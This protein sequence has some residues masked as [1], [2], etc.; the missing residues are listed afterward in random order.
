MGLKVFGVLEILCGA[1]AALMIP[2]MLLAQFLASRFN[3]D[4]A[5]LRQMVQGAVSYAV[6]AAAFVLVGIGS[7]QARRW[8]R[9]LSLILSWS[10]LLTGL[11]GLGYA[12]WLLPAI[13]SAPQAQGAA[14]PAQMQVV[15]LLVAVGVIGLFL[16]AVPIVFVCFYQSRHVK[17]TCEAFDPVPRWTDA[18]PLPVLALSLWLGFGALALLLSPL[19]VNGVLPVFGRLVPGLLG[20]LGYL[21]V[22]GVCGWLAWSL[23]RLRWTGWWVAVALTCLGA[24]SNFITFSRVDLVEMYRLMGYPEQQ[25]D[26]MRQTGLM[27]GNWVAYVAAGGAALMLGFLLFVGRYFRR[28]ARTVSQT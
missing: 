24:A 1:L 28:Q 9:A 20:C 13:L 8:G 14:I 7:L 23:Y 27:Q 4:A 26:M 22:G 3:P 25:L 18:C 2:L 15:I 16:I 21:A 11:A 17:A 10:W 6:L 19:S 12:I 5:P